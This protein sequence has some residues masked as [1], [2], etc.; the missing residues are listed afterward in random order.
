MYD[1][2]YSFP[3]NRC[4]NDSSADAKQIVAAASDDRSNATAACDVTDSFPSNG[5]FTQPEV[6]KL[7]TLTVVLVLI[8]LIICLVGVA[9][10]SLVVAV[11][12]KFAKMK[13]V[14]NIH[15]LNLSVADTMYLVGLPMLT[16]TVVLRSWVFGPVLCKVYYILTSINMFTGIDCTVN[17]SI[18]R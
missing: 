7:E 6:K 1:N 13:T 11:V 16:T 10:N 18:I 2:N 9:G 3:S 8:Y 14:T 4:H 5:S 15:I 17:Q 12:V